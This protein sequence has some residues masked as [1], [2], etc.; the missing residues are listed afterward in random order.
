[1]ALKKDIERLLAGYTIKLEIFPFIFYIKV[2][3]EMDF[4]NVEHCIKAIELCKLDHE[5]ANHIYTLIENDIIDSSQVETLIENLIIES[6]QYNKL[7]EDQEMIDS[8]LESFTDGQYDEFILNTD[9]KYK[10]KTDIND[11]WMLIAKKMLRK[12]RSNF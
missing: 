12:I 5:L 8:I 2:K 1:M 3:S 9:L 6:P 11:S 10:D 7:K 4:K